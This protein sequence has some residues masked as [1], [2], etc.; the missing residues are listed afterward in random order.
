MSPLDPK[1]KLVSFCFVCTVGHRICPTSP[2][3]CPIIISF[4]WSFSSPCLVR[5]NVPTITTVLAI[6]HTRFKCLASHLSC[7]LC[8][9]LLF[10]LMQTFQTA[11]VLRQEVWMLW[12]DEHK[13]Q[14]LIGN[15]NKCV[16]CEETFTRKNG[17][18]SLLSVKR[19]TSSQ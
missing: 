19:N 13:W 7:Q 15:L 11:A 2:H 4:F 14:H 1:Q 12:D 5:L 3:V 16:T 10:L 18:R 9:T 17:I 8:V 6:Y